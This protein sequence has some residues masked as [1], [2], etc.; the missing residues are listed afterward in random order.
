MAKM[1][2]GTR[3]IFDF[4]KTIGSE[5]YTADDIAAATGIPTKSV[6]GSVTSFTKK[7]LAVRTE[8]SVELE[9]GTTKKVKFIAL[10]P[11]GMAFDPDAAEDAE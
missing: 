5:N 1:K 6:N 11:A 3:K 2:E 4:L 9:D 10:T 8:A 7:G